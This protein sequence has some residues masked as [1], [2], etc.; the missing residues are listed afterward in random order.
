MATGPAI[1][2]ALAMTACAPLRAQTRAE[3]PAASAPAAEPGPSADEAATDPVL[4]AL[5]EGHNRERAEADL[6]PLTLHPKLNASALAHARDMAEH[7]KMA[8]EG[9][10]GSTPARRIER[11]GYHYRK[12]GEN[13]AFGQR[14]AEVVMKGWMNSPHH[15]ENILGDFSEMGAARVEDE[16]GVP[17]WCVNFGRPW[18][19]LDP[20]RAASALVEEINRRRI[21][22]ELSPLEADPTLA[23]AA[24]HHARVMA[25]HGKMVEADDDGSTPFDRVG[26]DGGRF[27][28]LAQA[29]ASGQPDA[30]AA[31]R[32]LVNNA[33][34]KASVLGDYSHVGVGYA[35]P[36]RMHQYGISSSARA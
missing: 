7:G 27:G 31:A 11:Q 4:A 23:A 12:C 3:A 36:K 13:V 9:S 30:P 19:R 5:L 2:T 22:A 29:T 1:L 10:D 24:E 20:A 26:R 35:R 8:H 17:Y 34:L 16:E 15:R 18:P 33:D 6:A 32:T 28:K 14:T 25:E 21:E